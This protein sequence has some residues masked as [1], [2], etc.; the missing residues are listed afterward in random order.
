MSDKKDLLN[1][2]KIDRSDSNN[3]E[4]SP[5]SKIIT[6]VVVSIFIL[7][8]AK[9]IFLSED[10]ILEVSAYKA[11]PAGQSNNSSASVLDA[12]GYVTALTATLLATSWGVVITRIPVIGIVCASV[13]G[14]SPVP[15]GKSTIR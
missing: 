8:V 4:K 5:L 7:V 15:G 3:S 14:I 11:I 13:N 6:I 1:D 2:L 9:F 10:E 12:S